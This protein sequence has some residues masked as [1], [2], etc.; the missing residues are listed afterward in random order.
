MQTEKSMF[1]NELAIASLTI[2]VT[3]FIQLFGLEKGITAIVF[4]IL[5]IRRLKV[6]QSQR[7]KNL[8][9][10]GIVLGGIY[11]ILA[12]AMLPHALE[13]AKKIMSTAY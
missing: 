8:A 4:G 10:A 7:G 2:G 11:T 9:I 3:S 12:L 5:A 1:Y 6:D 13:V